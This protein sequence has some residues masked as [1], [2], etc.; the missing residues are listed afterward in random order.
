MAKAT[1]DD[2]K[3]ILMAF[4]AGAGSNGTTASSLMSAVSGAYSGGS[5]TSSASSGEYP[6]EFAPGQY[7][8]YKVY[9][10]PVPER[11][12]GET[13][14]NFNQMGKSY[15]D[16]IDE[17][18]RMQSAEEHYR[19]LTKYIRPGMT[20]KQL[21][22]A[23]LMGRDEEKRLPAFWNES[24]SRRPFSVSSSAVSGIRLVPTG[25]GGSRVEVQWK[26]SPTWYTFKEYPNTYEGSL[27]AQ[28]LL[29]AD[30]IGR[31]VMPYQRN[32]RTI[33]FKHPENNYSWWNR[34][35]YDAGQAG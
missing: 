30:S 21:H 34:P 5:S 16:V 29:K 25:S 28:K 22:Q 23:E 15:A 9:N 1:A 8:V 18:G 33:K 3:K 19:A 7:H 12:R 14:G 27:A 17:A 2:I 32:G 26:S 6:R 20:P 4:L 24:S 11:K 13:T 10:I 31:A 35:N